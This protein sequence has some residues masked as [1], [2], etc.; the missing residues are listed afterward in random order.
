[1]TRVHLI[2]QLFYKPE[3]G[4][5]AQRA[6]L[7]GDRAM[8][9]LLLH[10]YEANVTLPAPL[11]GRLPQSLDLDTLNR[12]PPCPLNQGNLYSLLAYAEH[13]DLWFM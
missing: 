7:S 9:H 13:R 3:Q 6:L 11:V 12:T 10:T 5:L 4:T 2:D 8:F 1:M